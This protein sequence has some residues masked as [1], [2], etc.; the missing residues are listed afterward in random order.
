MRRKA[1]GFQIRRIQDVIPFL[2]KIRHIIGLHA[3][4]LIRRP[5]ARCEH[6]ISDAL[7][8]QRCLI[9]AAGR[10]IQ[11]GRSF[12]RLGRKNLP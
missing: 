8:V 1:G 9:Q 11:A 2:Y 10:D 5:G 7:S 3:Q 4:M 12:R 6:H